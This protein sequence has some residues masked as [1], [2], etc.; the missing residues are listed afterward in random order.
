MYTPIQKE[1]AMADETA[2]W[3]NYQKWS[4]YKKQQ[5]LTK[6]QRDIILYFEKANAIFEEADN[7]WGA[8][9]NHPEPQPRDAIKIVNKCRSEFF[10][11]KPP[12]IAK[13]HYDTSLK[14]F[15]I[16]KKYHLKRINNPDSS[17]LQLLARSAIPWEG[18]QF[19]EYFRI[20][21]ATGLFDHIEEE[22]Q[23]ISSK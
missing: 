16:I 15:E 14:L 3:Q 4:E 18:I 21:K 8:S 5:P 13:K 7:T 1:C 22:M 9:V 11:L 17:D 20:M 19:S 10:K 12:P 2:F 23:R 6:L